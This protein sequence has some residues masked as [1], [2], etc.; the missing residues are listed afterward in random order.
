MTGVDSAL[1][2]DNVFWRPGAAHMYLENVSNMMIKDNFFVQGLHADGANQD[3]LLDDL[4]AKSEWGYVGFS[5]GDAYGSVGSTGYGYGFGYGY[6]GS[7]TITKMGYGYGGEGGYGPSGYIP[8]GYGIDNANGGGGTRRLTMEGI[9][10]LKSR[11][12]S[13]VTFSGN[14]AKFNSGG[15][16]F[17]DEDNSANVF[18]D[19]VIQNNTF[20]D[21][22]NADPDGFC[23]LLPVGTS[24]VLWVV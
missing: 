7:D 6:D 14:S 8:S 23:R 24:P 5:G 19:I 21:F 3:G 2:D 15:I 22:I 16:Q 11:D 10:S 12:A 20:T 18:T 1:I 13:T 17:W 9:T 4:V